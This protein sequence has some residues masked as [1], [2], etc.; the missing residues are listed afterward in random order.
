MNN[1]IL[2][3]HGKSRE[4]FLVYLFQKTRA[5]R[6]TSLGYRVSNVKCDS[7]I[8]KFSTFSFGYISLKKN[9]RKSYISYWISDS[10]AC[11]RLIDLRYVLL[12]FISYNYKVHRPYYFI[13]SCGCTSL[14]WLLKFEFGR[15]RFIHFNDAKYQLIIKIN[16]SNLNK[17]IIVDT[18]LH[19]FDKL[20]SEYELARL[21]YKLI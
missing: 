7:V 1:I 13:L 3:S 14:L 20:E 5:T 16:N 21:F 19:L 2:K 10:K 4:R 8:C 15:A 6:A 11:Q 18:G 12:L 17:H 9:T